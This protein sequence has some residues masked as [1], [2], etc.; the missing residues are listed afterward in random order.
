[1]HLHNIEPPIK[2]SSNSSNN[3]HNAE[4]VHLITNIQGVFVNW[5]RPKLLN[6]KLHKYKSHQKSVRI[7]LLTGTL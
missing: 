7:Y 5:F 4:V 1:M 3:Q 2:K 6:V